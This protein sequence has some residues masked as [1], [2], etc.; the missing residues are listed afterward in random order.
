LVGGQVAGDA[1]VAEDDLLTARTRLV[2]VEVQPHRD[3]PLDGDHVGRIA[4]LD[5]YVDLLHAARADLCLRPLPLAEE[6]PEDKADQNNATDHDGNLACVHDAF[7]PYAAGA[8]KPRRRRL[9]VTT[10]TLDR[11]I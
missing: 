11:L 10:E 8:R 1:E 4:A 5:G 6:V 9:F 7:P 3:A 2:A